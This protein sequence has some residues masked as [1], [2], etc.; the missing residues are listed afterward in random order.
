[1]SGLVQDDPIVS[2]P[3]IL[4]IKQFLQDVQD[5]NGGLSSYETGSLK[6]GEDGIQDVRFLSL[7]PVCSV[8][9][10]SVRELHRDTRGKKLLACGSPSLTV[11]EV[12][13][14]KKNKKNLTLL[15]Q[16]IGFV[17]RF[18]TEWKTS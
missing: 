3:E 6:R 14:N 1:M 17:V 10:M 16:Y 13:K 11:P 12:K 15:F 9:S 4:G 5:A 2:T 8:T 18:V 7:S